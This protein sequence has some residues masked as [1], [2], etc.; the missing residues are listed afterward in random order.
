M[1][2]KTIAVFINQSAAD[3]AGQ[4]AIQETPDR[5]RVVKKYI[6]GEIIGYCVRLYNPGSV[7]SH[8]ER[9]YLME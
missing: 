4:A 6:R 2:D 5:Y 7:F 1:A 8:E 3:R 9:R